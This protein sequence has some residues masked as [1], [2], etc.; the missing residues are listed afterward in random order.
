MVDTPQSDF[1]KD[2]IIPDYI[3]VPESKVETILHAPKCPIIVF[4]NSKSGGQ[5]GGDLLVSFRSLLNENQVFD[6]LEEAPDKVLSRFYINLE[7]LTQNEDSIAVKIRQ[8]LRL[9]VAGGDG[10]AGWL[11][12]VVS[13]LKLSHPPPIATMPL[14]TGNNLPFAFGW[15]KRNPGTDC[16]SVKSFLV[17]VLK[18]EEMKIDRFLIYTSSSPH[19]YILFHC[20]IYQDIEKA[21]RGLKVLEE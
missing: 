1:L 5:H 6:L 14:G 16:H 18:A 2:F 12:G 7:R 4:I 8:K 19:L 15:G 11:L 20:L 9:I 17:R 13:D 3:L 21:L 10:T